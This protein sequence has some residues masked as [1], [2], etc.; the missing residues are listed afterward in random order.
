VKSHERGSF[1]GPTVID[2][3]APTM[4]VYR[5]EIF[6]PVLSVVRAKTLREAIDLIN[7]NPY[8]NGTASF[9][10]NGAA[11]REFERGVK[12]GLIGV[13]VPIP[14]PMAYYSFGGWKASLL[15][16][17]HIHG[18]EGVAFY[19]RAKVMTSRWPQVET[20][21]GTMGSC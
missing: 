18:P 7:S 14:V 8:G 9:T 16:D 2:H 15:G 12:V 19:T 10:S 11:A 21:S 20:G 3:V 5:E 1:L 17:R 13:N 6:G 4:D